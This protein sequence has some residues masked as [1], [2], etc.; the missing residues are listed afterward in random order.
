MGVTPGCSAELVEKDAS[1]QAMTDGYGYY[2]LVDPSTNKVEPHNGTAEQAEYQAEAKK[3]AIAEEEEAARQAKRQQAED[4][5]Q[6]LFMDVVLKGMGKMKREGYRIEHIQDFILDGNTLAQNQAKVA[7]VDANMF[8]AGSEHV[9]LPEGGAGIYEWQR[10]DLSSAISVITEDASRA[11]RKALLECDSEPYSR[12]S[13][14]N[15]HSNGSNTVYLGVA[16]TC[17]VTS[18]YGTKDQPCLILEHDW[19]VRKG[20]GGSPYLDWK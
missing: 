11:T 12:F 10:G 8:K 1:G 6:K 5:R 15:S 9:L 2:Y 14:C 20:T 7:I 13:G 16:S 3:R 19:T 4:A 17:T 18:L